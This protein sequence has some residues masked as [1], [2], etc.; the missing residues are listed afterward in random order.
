MNA[1]AR[2]TSRDL[3]PPPPWCAWTPGITVTVL[4][5]SEE[6]LNEAVGTLVETALDHVTIDTRRGRV[7]IHASTL[8]TG[9]IVEQPPSA[10]RNSAPETTFEPGARGQ[11]S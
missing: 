6:G 4:Y 11:Q 5:R 3:P 2:P 8:V 1:P 10:Q 9:R 7:F